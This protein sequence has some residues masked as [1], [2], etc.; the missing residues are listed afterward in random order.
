MVILKN[1]KKPLQR[2][3]SDK[4]NNQIMWYYNNI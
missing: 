3:N 1:D 2:Y 4:V